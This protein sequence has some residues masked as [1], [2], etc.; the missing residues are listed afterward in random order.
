MEGGVILPNGGLFSFSD[1]T[2]LSPRR[3]VHNITVLRIPDLQRESHFFYEEWTENCWVVQSLYN[4][5][6][7]GLSG[8]GMST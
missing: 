7:L 6:C 2:L 8:D 1:T 4:L 5:N 3:I